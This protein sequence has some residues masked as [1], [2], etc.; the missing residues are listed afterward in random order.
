[1]RGMKLIPA[2]PPRVGNLAGN[3]HIMHVV[4]VATL[5]PFINGQ[6]VTTG[7]N[8]KQA[9]GYYTLRFAGL[10]NLPIPL[11]FAFRIGVSQ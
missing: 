8:P 3:L 7:I 1:M 6:I 10:F 11:R 4:S 2:K 5:D 9:A